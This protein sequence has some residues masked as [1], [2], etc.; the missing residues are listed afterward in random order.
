MCIIAKNKIDIYNKNYKDIIQIIA[1]NNFQLKYCISME[2]NVEIKHTEQFKKW[3][4]TNLHIVEVI[5]FI[6]SLST[7]VSFSPNYCTWYNY[8][9]YVYNLKFFGEITKQLKLANINGY[10]TEYL[11]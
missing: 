3:K 4:S 5:T 7:I 9:A 10:Y 2:D 11:F 6:L 8:T 1:Q